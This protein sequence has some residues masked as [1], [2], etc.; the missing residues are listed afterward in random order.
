ML[1]KIC[2]SAF[3]LFCAISS[4]AADS[5]NPSQALPAV[6]NFTKN[7][8]VLILAPHP[9][10]ETIGAAG[11]IQQ[12]LSS[13]ADVYVACY[14]NGDANQLAFIVY[15]KRLTF[16]KGE[17]LHMG[18]VRRQETLAALEF[19]GVGKD[20][21]FFLGYPDIG[22]LQIMFKFWGK[23]KPYRSM[24][25]RVT[26]VPYKENLSPGAPYKG[27]SI[28]KDLK[29]VLIK[30]RPT[31][32][33]VSHPA[34]TNG[35]HQSLYL[36]LRVALWDLSKKIEP[37]KIYPYLVHCIGW[38]RP[39][40]FHPK[41]EFSPPKN[42]IDADISWYGLS[43]TDE[44]IDKKDKAFYLYKSQLPYNPKYLHTFSRKNELYGDYPDVTIKDYRPEFEAELPNDFKNIKEDIIYNNVVSRSMP[45]GKVD[46][47]SYAKKDNKLFIKLS[48]NRKITK[49]VKSVIYLLGYNKKV[50]FSR[51]PKLRL[52]VTRTKL[53]IYDKRARIFIND[54]KMNIDGN[55]VVVE[56][57]LVSLNSPDYILSSARAHTRSV[58]FETSAWRVLKLE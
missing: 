44:Q 28:L 58:P 34:D 22:T 14:T 36:F 42:L 13:G 54:A 12:A 41:L 19:F 32:I 8:R 23:A 24:L 3:F 20:K 7:D 35:D 47:L 2:L 37:P 53:L 56:I 6:E 16:L 5:A 57:P 40:G 43:L 49:A 46:F 31:K 15:E 38:P 30:T 11:V 10:D 51:M 9:D 1:K 18:E 52:L 55:S 50:N 29:A 45:R 33:F 39:R 48:F 17:F 26:N 21:V 4:I 27:E 25:T